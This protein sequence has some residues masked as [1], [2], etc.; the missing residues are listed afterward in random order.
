M[1]SIDA[2]SAHTW[3]MNF[4]V[5]VESGDQDLAE[6]SLSKIAAC[7]VD[8]HPALC[9]A[10]FTAERRGWHDLCATALCRALPL[11][12]D[13]LPLFATVARCIAASNAPLDARAQKMVWCAASVETLLVTSPLDVVEWWVATLF[14][15]A[16]DLSEHH[17][18]EAADLLRV[19]GA[20]C[21]RVKG[22]SLCHLQLHINMALLFLGRCTGAAAERFIAEARLILER[23]CG[24]PPSSMNHVN[25]EQLRGTLV[26]AELIH[27]L[28][29][30]EPNDDETASLVQ[31]ITHVQLFSAEWESIADLAEAVQCD[32]TAELLLQRQLQVAPASPT[33]FR[34]WLKL[35][36]TRDNQLQC[37]KL[38]LLAVGSATDADGDEANVIV[39]CCFV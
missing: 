21:Q 8:V 18:S 25:A 29:N 6:R 5:G 26:L 38:F 2:R 19:A 4:E 37:V 1:E 32:K 23:S 36:Q 35:C 14:H 33:I 13:P 12:P 10:A 24:V 39:A 15:F 11:A 16:Q 3:L 34:K 9:A 27:K 28:N 17:P 20:L 31:T 7:E 30:E 22:Q